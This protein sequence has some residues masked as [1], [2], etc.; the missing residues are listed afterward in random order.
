[1]TL[2]DIFCTEYHVLVRYHQYKRIK[3]SF[4]RHLL[5]A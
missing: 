5:D 2:D 4:V 3:R 1:L